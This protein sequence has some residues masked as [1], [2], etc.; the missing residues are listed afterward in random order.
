[1]QSASEVL[2]KGG[3]SLRIQPEIDNA[4]RQIKYI[5]AVSSAVLGPSGEEMGSEVT[6]RLRVD[7]DTTPNRI[8][9]L[10]AFV[11]TTQL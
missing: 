2:V 3:F 7:T 9:G 5:F 1:M 8:I 4:G 11:T 10:L 6:V